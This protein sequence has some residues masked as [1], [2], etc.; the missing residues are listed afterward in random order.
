MDEEILQRNPA[1]P[2]MNDEDFRR[3]LE[4]V[5]DYGIIMLDAQGSIIS[6][7]DGAERILGYTSEEIVGRQSSRF[8]LLYSSICA[9]PTGRW[10]GCTAT[11]ST[12]CWAAAW[13]S[14][15]PL[16]LHTDGLR[17]RWRW[18]DFPQLLTEKATAGASRLLRAL[19]RGTDDATVLIVRNGS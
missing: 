2:S 14:S 1:A 11:G 19:S 16:A 13:R 4:S 15:T 18:E 10:P 5:K 3:M 6:W 12:K 17:S 8:Y 9:L 7:N